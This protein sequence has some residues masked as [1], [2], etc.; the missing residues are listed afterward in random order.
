MKKCCIIILIVTLSLT[1][2]VTT[3]FTAKAE[4]RE[5][6][7]MQS[8]FF[9][10][11][12]IFSD[13]RIDLAV[14]EISQESI[15][16]ECKNKTTRDILLHFN[17]ALDGICQRMW[18]DVD[19]STV[20]A[21]KTKEVNYYFQEDIKN[22]EHNTLTI[23]G[24]GFVD[25]VE[26]M[27]FD[28]V[29]FELGGDSNPDK[30]ETGKTIFSS[31]I[32]DIEFTSLFA[33]GMEFCIEN[34]TNSA[35][36]FFI[37]DI[38]VNK[39]MDGFGS[40]FTIPAKSKGICRHYMTGYVE[41]FNGDD[42]D[43]FTASFKANLPTH[44]T[45]SLCEM[46][47][48]KEKVTS[49]ILAPDLAIKNPKEVI[50]KNKS[51]KD[52]NKNSDI[53]LSVQ[54]A[55]VKAIN[56][57]KSDLT[58]KKGSWKYKGLLLTPDD[59]K[60]IDSN[61]NKEGTVEAGAI[62]RKIEYLL[63]GFERK[64]NNGKDYCELV[65]GIKYESRDALIPYIENAKNLYGEEYPIVSVMKKFDTLNS[66]SGSFD[67]NYGSLG[68]Y[69]IVIEN[70][71]ECAKELM[72]SEEMLGYTIA[73]LSEYDADIVFDGTRCIIEYEGYISN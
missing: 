22:T 1:G 38:I 61:L 54:E 6:Q 73:M 47:Y 58:G 64:V 46:L 7:S 72:L 13:E 14:K 33:Q 11:K 67:Y 53:Q 39:D 51:L 59:C 68:K 31:D 30:L 44:G 32:L 69:S 3:S 34:K 41:N 40:A 50:E 2:F 28:V 10:G 5:I 29:D 48:D 57:T 15:V 36:A 17:I 45:V 52:D 20:M 66:V 26:Y 12:Q 23:A 18:S 9:V 24:D 35:L 4:G 62:Y 42:I 65:F 55:Y 71:S 60:W 49:T 8:A 19:E 43:S 37:E 70:T 56:L 27:S 21:G 63:Q 25:N 16:F